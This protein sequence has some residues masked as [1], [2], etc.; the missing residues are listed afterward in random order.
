MSTCAKLQR[1]EIRI[2]GKTVYVPSAEIYDRTVV[3]T[4]NWLRIAAVKDE[5]L[6]QGEIIGDP[7]AFVARMRR[8][9]L[10]ADILTFAQ[11]IPNTEPKYRYCLQWDNWAAT[12]TT[13]FSDW[14]EKRLPQESRK[15]VR[16]AA[17]RGVIVKVVQFDD[18]LVKGIQ[19]IYDETPV[20]QGRRFW[21]FGKDF[22]AVK[23]ENATYLDRSEFLGAYF[24][25]EL[26]GFVKI[27]YVDRIAT[28]IQILA[29]NE[30][31]DKRPINAL[32]AKAVEVCESKGI[33]CLLYGKY[34]YEGNADSALTEFKR[35]NGF[36]EITYPRYF[37]PLSLKG[38]IA[39]G[40]GLHKGLKSLIP[41][42]AISYLRRLRSQF[43]DRRYAGK[44]SHEDGGP[45]AEQ[46]VS[47]KNLTT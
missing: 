12:P 1:A 11:K 26:I 21:H 29:M 38:K 31:Q 28:L 4:G 17:K 14:W 3:V 45:S 32:L 15:N 47:E 7:K 18:E 19:K 20:R 24:K 23:R 6:V 44:E 22:E 25:D 41:S 37:L 35:R 9:H 39:I 16:R 30:H 13:S 43:Y 2:A 36:E 27:V 33:A 46:S 5:Q 42:S 8:S 40:L 10:R 34:I